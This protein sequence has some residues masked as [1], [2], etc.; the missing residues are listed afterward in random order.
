MTLDSPLTH[1]VSLIAGAVKYL[2]ERFDLTKVPMAGASGG[3]IAAV[4]AACGVSADHAFRRAY[5][6]SLKYNIWQE[7]GSYMGVWGGLVEEWLDELLPA[8]AHERCRGRITVVVTTLPTWRQVGISDFSDKRDLIDA[9]M[10]SSHIPL[11]LDRRVAKHC[12]GQPCVDGSFPDFFFGNCDMLT[13]GGNAVVFDYFDDKQLKRQGRMDML[14]LTS[15]EEL[16]NRVNLGYAFAR[17]LHERGAFYALE[18]QED[19]LLAGA[20]AA[21]GVVADVQPEQLSSLSVSSMDE[22]LFGSFG[23]GSYGAEGEDG[24]LGSLLAQQASPM[25]IADEEAARRAR[26]RG[27]LLHQ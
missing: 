8:D 21:L 5:E 15:L 25:T 1:A 12:R 13:R 27:S 22:D 17:R 2:A 16:Q 10:A 26:D 14:Q 20:A 23:S 4:L 6:L 19:V 11:V 24:S 9:V 3:S 7:P 18:Q